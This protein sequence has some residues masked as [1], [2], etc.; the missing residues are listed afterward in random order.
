MFFILAMASNLTVLKH[1]HSKSKYPTHDSGITWQPRVHLPV[2]LQ[3]RLQ[4]IPW[5][6]SIQPSGN[7]SDILRRGGGE[8]GGGLQLESR[9]KWFKTLGCSIL[10]CWRGCNAG[11]QLVNWLAAAIGNNTKMRWSKSF[12]FAR[13]VLLS[14]LLCLLCFVGQSGFFS[15]VK[16]CQMGKVLFS[17]SFFALFSL[18]QI[19]TLQQRTHCCFFLNNCWSI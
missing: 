3:G 14:L 6:Y 7:L 17:A 16:Y 11:G 2:T 18:L 1:N 15:F 13:F 12:L 10:G 5:V 19:P 9:S 8:S 4:K